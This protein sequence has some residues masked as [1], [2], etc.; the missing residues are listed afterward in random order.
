MEVGLVHRG[1]EDEFR[2]SLNRQDVG[3]PREEDALLAK[4][5]AGL[6][7]APLVTAAV[8]EVVVVDAHSGCQVRKDAH[9]LAAPDHDL[10]APQMQLFIAERFSRNPDFISASRNSRSPRNAST[11]LRVCPPLKAALIRPDAATRVACS[12]CSC[13][14]RDEKLE[15]VFL[16]RCAA[17]ILA[18]ALTFLLSA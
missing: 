15:R 6:N 4:Q 5:G 14:L 11:W 9:K 16:P 1:D 8:A 3:D 13:G 17:W 10:L 18:A 12:C 7:R 2:L